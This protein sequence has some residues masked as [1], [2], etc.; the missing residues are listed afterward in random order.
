M[1]LLIHALGV[2]IGAT[3]GM[4]VFYIIL[5]VIQIYRRGKDFR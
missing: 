3:I 1:G 5:L 4:V 2:A